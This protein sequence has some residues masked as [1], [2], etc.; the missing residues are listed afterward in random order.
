MD[1]GEDEVIRVW[2]VLGVKQDLSMVGC[3]WRRGSGEGVGRRGAGDCS[4]LPLLF[5]TQ[6]AFFLWSMHSW[7][8]R[9]EVMVDGGVWRR[10]GPSFSG[11]DGLE[12]TGRMSGE[13]ISPGST[14]VWMAIGREV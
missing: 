9:T 13:M 10:P 11:R 1:G 12:G 2:D 8:A 4:T 7:P 3:G 5:S 6:I 14:S